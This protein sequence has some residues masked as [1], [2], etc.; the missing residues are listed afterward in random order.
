MNRS[1][2]QLPKNLQTIRENRNLSL[3]KLA[4]LTGVSKSMLRQ[5]EI[6]QSNPTITTILKITDGLKI[7]LSALLKEQTDKITLKSFQDEA[8]LSLDP[9][10]Y[11]VYPLVPF[12]PEQP[13][14]IYYAK[15]G[16]GIRYDS[17]PHQ[18]NSEEYVFIL[19]GELVIDV[20]DFKSRIEKDQFLHFQADR[21]HSYINYESITTTVLMLISYLPD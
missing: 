5:I 11:R 14:E 16:P 7:P 1:E 2:T 3:D 4:D 9:V 12:H 20:G 21:P 6:G 10:G 15:I 18:D 17:E 13:F 19:N 8:P